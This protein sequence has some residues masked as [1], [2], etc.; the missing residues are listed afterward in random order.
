MRDQ[1]RLEGREE[2]EGASA[3]FLTAPLGGRKW[4]VCTNGEEREERKVSRLLSSP[5][6]LM[7]ASFSGKFLP[8]TFRP[9]LLIRA[10]FCPLVFTCD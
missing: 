2:R 4:A 8:R 7:A 10:A 6:C 3:Q 5:F 9:L 1:I